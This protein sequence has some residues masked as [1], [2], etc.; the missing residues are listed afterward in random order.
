M[1]ARY[2]KQFSIPEGFPALLKGFTREILRS[3]PE[4]I[5]EFGARYFAQLVEQRQAEEEQAEIQASRSVFELTS[6]ELSEFC[7]ELFLKFDEDE[8]GYLDRREF[9]ACLESAEL[10]LS[11]KDVRK[12]MSEADEN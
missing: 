12:I 5:Y 9:K 11:K 8:S 7:L 4:N 1:A 3:Q 10:G 2:Q 6:E